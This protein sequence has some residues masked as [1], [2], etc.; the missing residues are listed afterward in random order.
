LTISTHIF[1]ADSVNTLSYL[2][3]SVFMF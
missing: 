2:H 3:H 1:N